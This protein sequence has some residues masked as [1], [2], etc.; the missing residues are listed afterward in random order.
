MRFLLF[1]TVLGGEVEIKIPKIFRGIT[2][3][4]VVGTVAEYWPQIK[5]GLQDGWNSVK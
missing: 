3:W 1:L 4:G 2:F 5:S